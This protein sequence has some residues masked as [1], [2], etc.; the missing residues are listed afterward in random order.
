MLHT[1]RVNINTGS[2]LKSDGLTRDVNWPRVCPCL[3]MSA[4]RASGPACSPSTP[5]SPGSGGC[6]LIGALFSPLMFC[7]SVQPDAGLAP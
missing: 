4:V 3:D 2:A 7:P 5:T 1:R 6:G